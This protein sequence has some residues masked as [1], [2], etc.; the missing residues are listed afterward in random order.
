MSTDKVNIIE[1]KSLQLAIDIIKFSENPENPFSNFQTP[2]F[3]N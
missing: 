2:K 3:S 1:N